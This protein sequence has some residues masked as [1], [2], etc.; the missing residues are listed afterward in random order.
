MIGLPPPPCLDTYSSGWLNA[1][2]SVMF[3]IKEKKVR[4]SFTSSLVTVSVSYITLLVVIR[5][6]L[7]ILVWN[8]LVM[9]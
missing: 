8:S 4:A 9:A 5:V 1:C 6:I 7:M 2:P 3:S